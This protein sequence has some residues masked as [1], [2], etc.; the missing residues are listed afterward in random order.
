[1]Q[2][3]AAP[4]EPESLPAVAVEEWQALLEQPLLQQLRSAEALVLAVP[5]DAAG[6]GLSSS[7]SSMLACLPPEAQQ[8]VQAAAA[9]CDFKG[10]QGE[11]LPPVMLAAGPESFVPLLLLGLGGAASLTKEDWGANSYHAAGAALAAAAKQYSLE[12]TLLELYVPPAGAYGTGSHID[13]EAAA[14]A[15]ATRAMSCF[16]SAALSGLYEGS[17]RY[18]SSKAESKVKLGSIRLVLPAHPDDAACLAALR[19]AAERGVALAY[20]TLM[21][22]FLVEAPANVCTPSHLAA[23]AAHLAALDPA[24]FSLKVLDESQVRALR[25]GLFLGVA[26]GAAEPLKLLHLTYTP[27]GPVKQVVALV[28]KGLSFDSGGYNLKT[29]GGIHT[30]KC[31]MAGAG[32]VL[33]AARSLAVLQPAGVQVHF[34]AACCENMVSATAT[35]PGDVHVSAAGISVEVNDTDAEGRLTL[36]D[37]L[38]YAQ[39]QAKATTVVDIATLTGAAGIALGQDTGALFANDDALAASL[40][41]ASRRAGEKL[42]RMPLNKGL[43]K[44]LDS[45]IADLK[46]YAGRWGGA[47]TAALFLQQ[48]VSPGVTWGHLDV[49]GPAWDDD[50]GLPT[51]FG[52]ATLAEWVLSLQ[53]QQQQQ[54]Q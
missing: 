6:T 40:D 10:K 2:N 50:A 16:V 44:K 51:G 38:W 48:F 27:H 35:R 41:A 29:Q 8:A 42:W 21:S 34:I 19:A 12:N 33:G 3:F 14:A 52:A 47:I 15:A 45:P 39:T 23:A 28:G 25:M 46:N 13:E 32:A 43:A 36:A 9:Q 7:S 31:D 22:Q 24:H 1:M 37:A 4:F 53:Q 18:R 26:Q 5:E 20:G 17:V 49:A 30:M 11:V 54:Q